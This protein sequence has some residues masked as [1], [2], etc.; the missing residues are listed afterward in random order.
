VVRASVGRAGEEADLQRDDDELVAAV[1]AELAEAVGPLPPVLGTRVTRWGGG[2]PQYAVGHLDRVR[3]VRTA[4]AQHPGLAVAGA[5][6]DGVGVPACV[7]SGRTAAGT[8]LAALPPAVLAQNG[9]H[10]RT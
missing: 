4:L 8:A 2:L 1:L 9:R 10:D 3:R 5:A 6:L 7:A